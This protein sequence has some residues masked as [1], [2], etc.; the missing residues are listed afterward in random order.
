MLEVRSQR[1][2]VRGQRSE[3]GNQKLGVRG[4]LLTVICLLTSVICPLVQAEEL[5]IGYVNLAKVFDGYERTKASDAELESKG[6]QKEAQLQQR[7]DELKKLRESLELLNDKAKDTKSSE[8]E[9]KADELQ[10]FRT[11]TARDLR[12]ERDRIAKE[13]LQ[14]IQASIEDYGK[15]NGF[16]MVFDERSLLYAQPGFDVTDQVL[17]ALNSRYHKKP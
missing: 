9:A 13:I 17:Q 6:K 15:A 1:L 7:M 4:A 14:E 16:S 11:S 12:R 2:A 10:R 5:K 3:I 8:A